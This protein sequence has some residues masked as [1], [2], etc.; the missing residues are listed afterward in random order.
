MPTARVLA[1]LGVGFFVLRLAVVT[2]S[3]MIGGGRPAC[4]AR[5]A[6]IIFRE[7]PRSSRS[8][9]E[10]AGAAGPCRGIAICPQ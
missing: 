4:E 7:G 2:W 5:C 9:A 1:F 3:M 8:S 10:I 6:R